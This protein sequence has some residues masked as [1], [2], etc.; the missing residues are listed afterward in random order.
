MS[1]YAFVTGGSRGIGRAVCV[2]LAQ[3]GFCVIVNYV[4]NDAAAK[5]TIRLKRPWRFRLWPVKR[6]FFSGV[7]GDRMVRRGVL[8]S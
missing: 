1:K 6:R 8:Q 5:E 3:M 4:S 2:K 7:R